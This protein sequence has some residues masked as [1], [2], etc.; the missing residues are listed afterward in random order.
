MKCPY[1]NEE[2]ELGYLQ[3]SHSMFWG[4]EKHKHMFRP[5]AKKGELAMAINLWGCY[6]E[7]YLCKKCNVM[8]SPLNK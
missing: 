2:M 7:T 3:S 4:A 5:S 1:C 6:V 8:I